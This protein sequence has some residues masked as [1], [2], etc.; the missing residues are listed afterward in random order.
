MSGTSTS[1][2]PPAQLTRDETR[3]LNECDRE[4]LFYRSLPLGILTFGATQYAMSKN[5]ITTKAKWLKLGVGLFAGYIIGKMSYASACKK[6]ILTQIPDSSLARMI[7]GVA[8]QYN[9]SDVNVNTY[10]ERQTN[11]SSKSAIFL[12]D[13]HLTP[14][15][16]NQYGDPIYKTNK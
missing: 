12:P 13:T 15:D 11:E 1:V 14:V 8:E 5:Y 10:Q 7:T 16:V 9:T 2:H 6:K 3:I 4:S